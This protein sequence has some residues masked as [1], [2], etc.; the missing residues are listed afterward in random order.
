M[1]LTDE[2]FFLSVLFKSIGE[3]TLIGTFFFYYVINLDQFISPE[4]MIILQNALWIYS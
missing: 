2:F 3:L 1:N 4:S